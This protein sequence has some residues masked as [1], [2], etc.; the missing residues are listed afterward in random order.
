MMNESTPKDRQL[1]GAKL[2]AEHTGRFARLIDEQAERALE[3]YGFTFLYS[4][5]EPEAAAFL[6]SLDMAEESS[7]QQ[8]LET[9]ALHR[10]GKMSE[11]EA[12]YK[13][14]L[15]ENKECKEIEFNLAVLY[16][17]RGEADLAKKH[18]DNFEKYLG[19]L[20][21]TNPFVLDCRQRVEE[22]KGEL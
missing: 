10:H 19:G 5:E 15:A 16:A 9:I 22:L 7:R 18:L 3:E 1:P 13:K 2:Y 6:K 20:P 17:Q 11:A 8:I 12:G 14:L 21:E 4:V